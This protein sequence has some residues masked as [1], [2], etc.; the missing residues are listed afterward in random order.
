MFDEQINNSLHT[1][2]HVV[3]NSLDDQVGAV[4]LL[5]NSVYPGEA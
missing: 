1:I 3:V 5:V 4:G 2:V